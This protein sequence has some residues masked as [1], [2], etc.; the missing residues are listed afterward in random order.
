MVKSRVV[1]TTAWCL[2]QPISL[3]L[4]NLQE[5]ADPDALMKSWI[6]TEAVRDVAARWQPSIQWV[7]EVSSAYGQWMVY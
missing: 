4:Q 2:H 5:E 7:D 6:M 3:I 1:P